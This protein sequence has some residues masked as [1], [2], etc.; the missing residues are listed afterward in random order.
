MKTIDILKSLTLEQKARLCVGMN[1]WM[2]QNFPE[3]G[4]PSL[5]MSDGPHGLRKQDL[6]ASDHLG[7]NDSEPSVCYPTGSLAA[8]S[9]DRDLIREMGNHLG[10]EASQLDVDILLGPAMNI[11]RSPLCGRNFEY[12]SEDP[13]LTGQLAAAFIQGVQSNGVSACPKHFVANNQETRRKAVDTL[14][15]ERTLREI[16][17]AGFETAIKEGP[18]WSLMSSYN[19]VNGTYPA[20]HTHLI[21]EIVR[22]EWGFAGALITDWGAMDQ[23]AA[24]IHAGLTLQMPGDDG[25]SARKLVRAV[26]KGEISEA[27]LDQ[28]VTALLF[29][30]EKTRGRKKGEKHGE[31]YHEVAY[32]VASQSMILL[33]NESG[34]LPLNPQKKIAVIGEMAKQPRFQGSGSSHVN[35][36]RLVDAYSQIEKICPQLCYAPGYS[37]ETTTPE[38]IAEAARIA[39]NC[40][41]VV[42]FAGLPSSYEAESYDRQDMKMPQAHNDLIAAVAQANPEV[43]VVLSNG[44]PVEIPWLGQA[45]GLLEAYLGG[46]ASGAAIADILFGR[47][48]P[49][50]KLA[51]TFPVKLE[52]NPSY[53][54]FPGEGDRV[55]YREGIFVGYRYYEKKKTRP[56]FAFGHGLSYTTYAYSDLK[57]EKS[58][59]TDQEQLKV[60]FKVKNTGQKAGK[61]II[62]LYVKNSDYQI[63]RAVKELKE[64]A[65]ISLAPGEEKEVAFVL[66]KRAF[67]YY[68]VSLQDWHVNSGDYEI[69]IGAA[70]DD[71]RLSAPVHVQSTQKIKLHITRNTLLLDI[72][73]D[74]QLEEAFLPFYTQIKPYLPFNLNQKDLKTDKM[75][76][77]MVNNMTLNS[78]ASY[79][80][81]FL[82]DEELEKII[83][84]LNN[85]Q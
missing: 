68:D 6:N 52:D 46:E 8:C 81:R 21:S 50:G 45:K 20:E 77:S 71:I 5:F 82:S 47:V 16:Y 58:S 12:Y 54:N 30:I 79:V 22:G 69:C 33:K 85:I 64:F 49:S 23:I 25:T 41:Q 31:Q 3:K 18:S 55:E 11:K 17:L 60:S 26:E 75:A 15:D 24:S 59:L 29:V 10:Q 65:K 37:D 39:K 35:V 48:N 83:Q 43:V 27:E 66:G 7:L 53:L 42:L 13:Y 72:L 78:L 61:E 9:W 51:E 1:F 40:D 84:I 57:L 4:I 73:A 34:I 19:K 44:S 62:Q 56:A 2:T 80:G 63:N 28:A 70:S 32:Q 67:A 38:M 74:P 76:R 14:I 36:F